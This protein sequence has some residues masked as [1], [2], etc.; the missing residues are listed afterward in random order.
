MLPSP[1]KARYWAVVEMFGGLPEGIWICETEEAAKRMAEEVALETGGSWDEEDGYWRR[2][3]TEWHIR[4]A[5]L[6]I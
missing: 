1:N 5:K 4:Q 6:E 3:D 2:G